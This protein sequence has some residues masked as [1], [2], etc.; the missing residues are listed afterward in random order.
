MFQLI[1]LIVLLLT[2]IS[3]F[4][5]IFLFSR[6]TGVVPMPSSLRERDRVVAILHQ[7]GHIN[8]VT[9]LGSGWGGL[10][11]HMALRLNNCEITAIERSPVPYYFSRLATSIMGFKSISHRRE[12]FLKVRLDSGKAFVSYLSGPAMKELRKSFERD[13]PEEGVLIT[14]AFAMPG[15]TPTRVEHID[16]MMHSPI[17]VYEY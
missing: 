17:Y 16:T 5:L 12:D 14:V 6:L 10:A 7:Y 1:I 11:R 2:A 4:A 15:W 8:K 13:L 9:D 3:A